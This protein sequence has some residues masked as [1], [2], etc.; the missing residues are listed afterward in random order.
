MKSIL[1]QHTNKCRII[2][3]FCGNWAS[4]EW[5]FSGLHFRP[6][7]C[8]IFTLITSSYSFILWFSF[9]PLTTLVA[10]RLFSTCFR[11]FYLQYTFHYRLY[12][13]VCACV[14]MCS[15]FCYFFDVDSFISFSFDPTDECF[16]SF[17]SNNNNFYVSF[18][19]LCA[20]FP[21]Q[22]KMTTTTEN[23]W[24]LNEKG[25]GKIFFCSFHPHKKFFATNRVF[26]AF[27]IHFLLSKLIMPRAMKAAG[28]LCERNIFIRIV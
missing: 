10:S 26:F 21:F 3:N 6:E 27:L 14:S 24:K 12:C 9:F 8:Y 25:S 15:T 1:C 16:E 18:Y 4:D 2:N 11:G 13:C 19:W 7:A 20:V 5:I 23:I 28:C 22:I 17:A